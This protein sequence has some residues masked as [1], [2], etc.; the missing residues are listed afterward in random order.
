MAQKGRSPADVLRSVDR[1]LGGRRAPSRVRT[2]AAGHPIGVGLSASAPFTLFFLGTSPGGE[3]ADAAP[4]LLLGAF[5]GLFFSLTALAERGRQRRPVR[6]GGWNGPGRH[7]PSGRRRTVHAARREAVAG[8][9]WSLLGA[10]TAW[11]VLVT[12]V[13]WLLGPVVAGRPADLPGCAASALYVI[14]LGEFGDRLR[15]RRAARRTRART[16][17]G[18][19]AERLAAVAPPDGGH[20]P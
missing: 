8:V 6:P 1:A 16:H 20:E 7:A 10:W 17:A 3:P 13:L 12:A 14:V 5:V 18:G 4:A 15:R 11:W 9:S 2:W 19:Q